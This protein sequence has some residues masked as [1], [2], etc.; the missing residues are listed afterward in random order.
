MDGAAYRR[1]L[2]L[3]IGAAEAN[4]A[5]TDAVREN[6]RAV[7]EM[8]HTGELTE[9][10]AQAHLGRLSQDLASHRVIQCRDVQSS[11]RAAEH[12]LP[13]GQEVMAP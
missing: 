5:L 10:E 13:P 9:A 7:M 8:R 4:D 6:T 1:L 11:F 12:A 2:D 3:R